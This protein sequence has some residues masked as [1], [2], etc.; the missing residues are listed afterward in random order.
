MINLDWMHWT[1][2][3]LGILAGVL[4]MLTF[5]TI[6]DILSP[7][8]KRKGILPFG[9]TRGER[10]FLS[11]ITLIGTTILWMAFLPEREWYHAFPVAAVFIILVVRWG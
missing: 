10:L 7:S 1:D 8:V 3:T 2:P 11:I 4:A 5:M 6:W 9:Y